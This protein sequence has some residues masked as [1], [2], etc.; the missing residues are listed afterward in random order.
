MLLLRLTYEKEELKI[1]H[2]QCKIVLPKII[3]SENLESC[4]KKNLRKFMKKNNCVSITFIINKCKNYQIPVKSSLILILVKSSW[5]EGKRNSNKKIIC[6]IYKILF[7][8][9]NLGQTLTLFNFLKNF[10]QPDNFP[11]LF[12]AIG[13]A[14]NVRRVKYSVRIRRELALIVCMLLPIF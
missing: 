1:Y 14:R 8:A 13:R 6:L 4:K 10:P 9:E 5:I 11:S 7:K 3:N 12:E 2:F